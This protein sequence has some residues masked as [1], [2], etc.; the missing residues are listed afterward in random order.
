MKISK[1]MAVL[2]LATAMGAVAPAFAATD[3]G[4]PPSDD[5]G[6]TTLGVDIRHFGGSPENVLSALSPSERRALINNC[7][8]ALRSPGDKS[9]TILSFCEGVTKAEPTRLSFAEPRRFVVQPNEMPTP[10]GG[11]PGVGATPSPAPTYQ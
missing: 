4:G 1:L 5:S 11:E 9:G 8:S 3:S 2:S 7:E 10:R 6:V